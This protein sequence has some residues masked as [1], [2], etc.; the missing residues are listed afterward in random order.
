MSMAITP[1]KPVAITAPS[2]GRIDTPDG[3]GHCTLVAS[4][5]TVAFST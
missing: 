1:S 2:L 3:L 4:V 5:V